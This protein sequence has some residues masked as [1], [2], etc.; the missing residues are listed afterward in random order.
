MGRTIT[1]VW[2]HS[3]RIRSPNYYTCLSTFFPA[4]PASSHTRTSFMTN[5][6]LVTWSISSCNAVQEW[7]DWLAPTNQIA[8]IGI[9]I[10]IYS[11]KK[12]MK[13][14][15]TVEQVANFATTAQAATHSEPTAKLRPFNNHLSSYTR[16][17]CHRPWKRN[18]AQATA[19]ANSKRHRMFTL[20]I[21]IGTIKC[22]SNPNARCTQ[23][24]TYVHTYIHTYLHT[25]TP[26]Y[27]LTGIPTYLHT[28][29]PKYLLALHTYVHTHI[30]HITLHYIRTYIH[31]DP[32]TYIH[33][34][35]AL[36]NHSDQYQATLRSDNKRASCTTI[37]HA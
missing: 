22:T 5:C 6:I 27:L 25:Y 2:E 32:H 18:L 16:Q 37:E 36:H 26:T 20:N 13:L 23:A 21:I 14:A 29:T 11:H 30:H 28:Y 9:C 19:Q 4:P 31:T 33:A 17:G 10:T 7:G 15:R 8:K 3:Y 24:H 12:T 34:I 35:H 1:H